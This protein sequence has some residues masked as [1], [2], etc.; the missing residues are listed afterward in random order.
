EGVAAT[1]KWTEG[2]VAFTFFDH[3][4]IERAECAL[5]NRATK[6]LM[7]WVAEAQDTLAN[8]PRAWIAGE[9]NVLADAGSRAPWQSRVGSH[10]AIPA[11]SAR[12]VRDFVEKPFAHPDD[13]PQKIEQRRRDMGL[14]PWAAAPPG[15]GA[16]QRGDAQFGTGPFDGCPASPPEPAEPPP[17]PR[18]PPWLARAAPVVEE[19]PPQA[20]AGH[21]APPRPPGGH[22]GM[23]EAQP[24]TAAPLRPPGGHAGV[25]GVQAAA[26]APL[27]PPGGR[28]GMGGARPAADAP[29]RLPGGRAGPGE[30]Q[31]L[32]AEAPG[33]PGG[34]DVPAPSTPSSP[35]TTETRLSDIPGRMGGHM[36]RAV[37]QL[38]RRDRDFVDIG[39]ASGKHFLEVGSG[40]EILTR[41]VREKGL[42]ATGP[43][44][45]KTGWDWT[46]RSSMQRLRTMIREERCG[47][48]ATATDTLTRKSWRWFTH[49]PWSWYLAAR[50]AGGHEHAKGG[51]GRLAAA[52]ATHPW[53]FGVAYAA[54]L[55][56][57]PEFLTALRAALAP[58]RRQK[59]DVQVVRRSALD[60]THPDWPLGAAAGELDVS[61]RAAPTRGAERYR[62]ADEDEIYARQREHLAVQKIPATKVTYMYARDGS[63]FYA[64]HFRDPVFD[65][66]GGVV[67]QTMRFIAYGEHRREI[68]GK[69]RAAGFFFTAYA[70]TRE[71]SG[72]G[73]F[74]PGIAKPT[75]HHGGAR[76]EFEVWDVDCASSLATRRP[77]FVTFAPG[78][79]HCWGAIAVREEPGLARR[80]CLGHPVGEQELLHPEILTCAGGST[81]RLRAS[82]DEILYD[83]RD[84]VEKYAEALTES[85]DARDGLRSGRLFGYRA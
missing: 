12:P 72:L 83:L 6:K 36:G 52:T 68:S 18:Q 64:V 15:R 67:K 1:S 30:V 34:R 24:A 61:R 58:C 19:E 48:A 26:A 66:R 45:K 4:N 77:D 69:G 11:S 71:G 49:A 35:T 42:A 75:G 51:G 74:G 21:Q 25:G 23:G 10:L 22:A 20:P 78:D 62:G 8:A 70:A 55:A 2:F 3:E 28:A 54:C 27:R 39:G 59:Q 31:Q 63:E 82:R 40:D 53:Q 13:L 47:M 16:Q 80:R 14:E 84:E 7:A 37:A 85:A 17:A 73:R 5:K 60:G 65:I 44:D 46:R 79:V 57:A 43:V 38:R 50:C 41:C 32:A 56:K 76:N 33:R 29:P 9:A 81:G